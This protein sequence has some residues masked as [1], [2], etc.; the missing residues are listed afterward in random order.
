MGVY[1]ALQRLEGLGLVYREGERA[2][3]RT[4]NVVPGALPPN[5]LRGHA[6]GSRAVLAKHRKGPTTFGECAL[7]EC[8]NLLPFPRA[9]GD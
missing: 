4:Y 7:A 9:S 2:W 3:Y 5:D 8:L 6:H 1:Q